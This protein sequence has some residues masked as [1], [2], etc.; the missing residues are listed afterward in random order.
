MLPQ[1]IPLLSVLDPDILRQ[2]SLQR[3]YRHGEVI[4]NQGEATTGLWIVLEGRIGVERVGPDGHVSSTGIW[5]AGEIIGIVGLWDSTP[6]PA[7]ART[8]QTPTEVLWIARNHVIDLQM[9]I[10][11]FGVE[12]CRALAQRLRFVQESSADARGRPVLIQVAGVLNI[13]AH[14]MGGNITLTHE[15]IAHM[16]GVQRETVTRALNTLVKQNVITSRHG[17]LHVIDPSGLQAMLG[18]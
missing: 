6:Y 8:L 10:P 17:A 9:S 4:F 1:Q 5:L 14:R 12:M 15:E 7:T 11:L 13:L 18:L 2:R 3:H 16:I